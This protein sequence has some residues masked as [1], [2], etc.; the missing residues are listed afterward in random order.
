MES[1]SEKFLQ[2]EV[3]SHRLSASC[4]S[5]APLNLAYAFREREGDPSSEGHHGGREKKDT[6]AYRLKEGGGGLLEVVEALL[7][8]RR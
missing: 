8:L 5:S 4:Y 6:L 7:D 2:G 3:L 1:E